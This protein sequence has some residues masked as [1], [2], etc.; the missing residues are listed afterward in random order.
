MSSGIDS[1]GVFS[2]SEGSGG[3]ITLDIAIVWEGRVGLKRPGVRVGEVD[4]LLL[5]LVRRI[6]VG[7]DDPP[8]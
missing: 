6:G 4:G 2:G 3:G 8:L 5:E 1:N 7:D